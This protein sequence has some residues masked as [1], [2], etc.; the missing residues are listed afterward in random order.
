[1]FGHIDVVVGGGDVPVSQGPILHSS[2]PN[3][4]VPLVRALYQSLV[5]YPALSSCAFFVSV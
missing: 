4:I 2:D 5:T 1:M 3:I